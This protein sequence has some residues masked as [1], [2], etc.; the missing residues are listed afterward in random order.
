MLFV[1]ALLHLLLLL[2]GSSFDISDITR[3]SVLLVIY[4]LYK[5][6]FQTKTNVVKVTLLIWSN[7]PITLA[8]GILNAIFRAFGSMY[9]YKTC[10]KMFAVLF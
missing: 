9:E 2:L 4:G 5:T 7:S 3:S 10:N 8:A 1:D 6:G